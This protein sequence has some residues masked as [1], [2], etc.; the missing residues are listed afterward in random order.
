MDRILTILFTGVI[1]TAAFSDQIR[2]FL[3][4]TT[5]KKGINMTE[6]KKSY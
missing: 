3:T 1:L 4:P 2:P 5:K 6:I